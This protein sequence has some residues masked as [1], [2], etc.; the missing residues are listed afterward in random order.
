M[1]SILKNR[2]LFYSYV[3]VL[4]YDKRY[5]YLNSN[6]DTRTSTFDRIIPRIRKNCLWHSISS[7]I[8][9]DFLV[10]SIILIVLKNITFE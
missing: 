10:T 9:Y 6:T 8:Y 2:D 5:S 7:S 3:L 1:P 4:D